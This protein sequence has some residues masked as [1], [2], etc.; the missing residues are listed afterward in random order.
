[1]SSIRRLKKDVDHLTDLIV[2]DCLQVIYYIE[3]VDTNSVYDII[4]EILKFRNEIR[5]RM[6]HPDGKD[7]RK[8]N[9][10]YYKKVK[11]DLVDGYSGYYKKLSDIIN[12]G[13]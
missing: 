10:Q 7:N 1:M 2:S 9:K 4:K 13:K 6:N 12:S 3:S 5:L 11:K 8:V